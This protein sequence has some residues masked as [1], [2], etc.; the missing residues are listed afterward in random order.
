L[1]VLA[2][3]L[4]IHAHFINFINISS[5]ILVSTKLKEQVWVQQPG[6]GQGIQPSKIEK[7]LSPKPLLINIVITER[8]S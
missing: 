4:R 6:F 5:F 2:I 1:P 7:P 3:L 8:K